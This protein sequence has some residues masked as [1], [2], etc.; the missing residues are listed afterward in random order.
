MTNETAP[1]SVLLCVPVDLTGLPDL[2]GIGVEVPKRGFDLGDS[3][4]AC[5][6][7]GRK[8]W[9]GGMQRAHLDLHPE[10]LVICYQCMLA[11]MAAHKQA[12]GEVPELNMHSLD[13]DR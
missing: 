4:G 11:S 13:P 2:T 6:P 10:A 3:Q 12:T 9:I 1:P 8:V 7:C 5:R